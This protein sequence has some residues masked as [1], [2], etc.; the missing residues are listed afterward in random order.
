M[1]PLAKAHRL[2]PWTAVAHLPIEMAPAYEIQGQGCRE[3]SERLHRRAMGYS[4]DLR[5]SLKH[6]NQSTKTCGDLSHGDPGICSSDGHIP[7]RMRGSWSGF[8]TSD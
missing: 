3:C 8:A 1:L 5:T 4:V 6:A 2:Q 7:C